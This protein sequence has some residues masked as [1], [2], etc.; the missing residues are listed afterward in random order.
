MGRNRRTTSRLR[1]STQRKSNTRAL[2]ATRRT[3]GGADEDF[4]TFIFNTDKITTQPNTD[5]NY[6]EFGLVHISE[7]TGVNVVRSTITS[8]ASFFGRKG[9][10][11]AVYDKLRNDTLRKLN[12]ILDKTPNSKI[13]N[14]RLE[15]D[16][17]FP[18]LL[19]HHAYGT[20]LQ[21]RS[22]LPK[23]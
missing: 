1:K 5:P 18:D 16:N 11:N 13:C 15:F 2:S 23:P 17:P 8:V 6:K 4:S 12:H 21:K 14:L 10:D 20:L 7:S 19:Y 22:D 9:V 3:R